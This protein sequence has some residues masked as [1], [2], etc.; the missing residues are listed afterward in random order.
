[1]PLPINSTCRRLLACLTLALCNSVVRAA[2]IPTAEPVPAS[3]P[4]SMHVDASQTKGPLRPI[5][6]YFG[7]D[8]PNFTYMKDGKKLLSELSQLGSQTVFIRTHHLLTSGDGVP[9]LKWGSTDIYKED[10]QGRP[11]Y[12]WTIIDRIFDTYLELGLKPFV[13]LG[14]MPEALSTHPQ[15]Y[16]HHPHPD[17]P[18]WP[19]VGLSYPPKDYAKWG[20]LCYQLARHCVEKYGRAEV[21]Q[22]RW[23]VWNEPNIFYWKAPPSEYHKLYDFAVDGVRRALP[24]ARVGGPH[25]AGGPGGKF[26]PNFLVHC[27]RGTN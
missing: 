20:E 12:S 16:P 5:W 17:E 26:L 25:T 2:D 9:A 13:E 8:E 10:D 11:I 3:F 27:L 24:A 21:E 14:F 19:G 7:Y 18:L 15:D 6:R 1:M 4:V 23:E 22:W